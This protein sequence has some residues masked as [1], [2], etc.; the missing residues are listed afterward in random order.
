[1][2]RQGRMQKI[3][4]TRI[5]TGTF[6]AALLGPLPPL[7]PDLR[8]LYA[9]HLADRDA[10]GVGLDHR[11]HERAEVRQ[12]GPFGQRAQRVGAAEADLHLLEHPR[13]LVGER[14]LRVAGHLATA[15]SN[16]RPD[17]TEI[18]SRSIASGRARRNLSARS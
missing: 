14:A 13:E 2:N 1:M 18:V 9:Q 16:P 12:V 10:E 17:S 5:F 3:S 4:G 6:C 7:H 11:A 15:A 8:G